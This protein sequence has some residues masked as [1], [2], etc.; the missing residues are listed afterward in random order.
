MKILTGTRILLC[1]G[2]SHTFELS[3]GPSYDHCVFHSRASQLRLNHFALGKSEEIG[4]RME[5]SI[6]GLLMNLK[7]AMK[8]DV[9]ETPPDPML[10]NTCNKLPGAR[11]AKLTVF[12]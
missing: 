4:A 2:A 11:N 5:L 6:S 9:T 10:V 1:S 7:L 3:D 8:L 12:T